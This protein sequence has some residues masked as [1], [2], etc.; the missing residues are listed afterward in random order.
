MTPIVA[1]LD[2]IGQRDRGYDVVVKTAP[3]FPMMTWRFVGHGWEWRVCGLVAR[4]RRKH[5]ATSQ[6]GSVF[7]HS[8]GMLELRCVA[9]QV[10][11][12]PAP[13]KRQRCALS[14]LLPEARKSA[15]ELSDPVQRVGL[16]AFCCI[17][18]RALGSEA[19]PLYQRV[20]LIE[21]STC[22]SD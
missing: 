18:S 7:L 16:T 6:C 10:A 1:V 11:K 2:R 22:R 12:R 15:T 4:G 3:I 21:R 20:R 8:V 13:C 9:G 5:C 14:G 19:P 17:E